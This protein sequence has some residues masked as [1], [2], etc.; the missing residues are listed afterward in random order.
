MAL[1]NQLEW[2]YC[3]L[4]MAMETHIYDKHDDRADF[5]DDPFYE[6]YFSSQKMLE[7]LAR[8]WPHLELPHC[9]CDAP[10]GYFDESR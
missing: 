5:Y 9:V 6:A 2:A 4:S 3:A 7:D 1:A 8:D 10:T